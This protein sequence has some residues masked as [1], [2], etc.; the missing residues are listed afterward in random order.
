[1]EGML[2]WRRISWCWAWVLLPLPTFVG[3][4][5]QL[6]I[7]HM[8]PLFNLPAFFWEWNNPDSFKLSSW[9]LFP[10][11]IIIFTKFFSNSP[12]HNY[13]WELQKGIMLLNVMGTWLRLFSK[14][15]SMGTDKLLYSF[16]S[17]CGLISVIGFRGDIAQRRGSH[18]F[19]LLLLLLI[20]ERGNFSSILYLS[21]ISLRFFLCINLIFMDKHIVFC[22]F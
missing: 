18:Q 17:L 8:I 19:Q 4:V 21:F 6:L 11:F 15:S 5:E 16:T 12:H 10:S 3:N 20:S 7:A 13:N 2:T 14:A 1:M 9:Y 22:L